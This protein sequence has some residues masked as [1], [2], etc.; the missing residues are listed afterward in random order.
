MNVVLE[1]ID[2]QLFSKSSH[3]KIKVSSVSFILVTLIGASYLL[4]CSILVTKAHAEREESYS[5]LKSSDLTLM[6]SSLVFKLI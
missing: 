1:D 5:C 4:K 2:L 3:L 6:L